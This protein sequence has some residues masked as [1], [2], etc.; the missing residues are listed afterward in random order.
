MSPLTDFK[1]TRITPGESNTIVDFSVFEGSIQTVIERDEDLNEI[2]VE[3][4][5]RDGLLRQET[6]Y[7]PA[8]ATKNVIVEYLKN[9]LALDH[10]RSPILEQIIDE[11]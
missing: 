10:D 7:L 5:V 2:E 4:Y 3:R 6:A 1:I 11:L 9:E 8:G